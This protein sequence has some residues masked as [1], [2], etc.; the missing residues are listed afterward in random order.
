MFFHL[1]IPELPLSKIR[2]P[3]DELYAEAY[4]IQKLVDL[5]LDNG[6]IRLFL[7]NFTNYKPRP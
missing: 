2:T 1:G 6:L 5:A 7:S 3:P 4:S